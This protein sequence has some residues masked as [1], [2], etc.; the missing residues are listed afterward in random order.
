MVLD[1][2]VGPDGEG[3]PL[4]WGTVAKGE[5]VNLAKCAACHGPTGT[6]GS[7]DRLV[8][9]KLPLKTIASHWS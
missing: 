3:L 4:G 9:G 2:V 7:M 6:E 5:K 1:I 8:E